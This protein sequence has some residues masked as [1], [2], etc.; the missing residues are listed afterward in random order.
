MMPKRLIIVSAVVAL[1]A[2]AYAAGRHT[3][4]AAQATSDSAT[5]P[6]ADDHSSHDLDRGVAVA[7]ATSQATGIPAG[8]GTVA[9]RLAQSPRHGTWEK[10]P[11]GA[12]TIMAW[13]VYP[14]RSER[15]PVVI[16]I[17]ENTGLTTWARGVADQLAA[18]GF[19]GIAP[20]L[21]SLDRGVATSDTLTGEQGR[22]LIGR[23][24]PDRMNAMV[25]AVAKY[26]MG[27][28]AALPMYGI[29]GFCWGGAASFNHAVH[30][31]TGL[32]ASVVYY[33]S[34][35][36]AER[37]SA[38][39]VPVLGLY[40][41]NDARINAGI[42]ATDSAMKALGKSFTHHTYAGAGHGFLRG[43]DGNAANADA[44]RQAWPQT[45]AFFRQHLRG[46]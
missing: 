21:L 23:V 41:G 3:A 16:A 38:I 12:D 29:V 13:V 26:G 10:I 6:H 39:R 34:A 27:L 8:A 25:D 24:T 14:E 42:P 18:D 22:A 45:I 36:P 31:P 11:M 17:H 28:P 1:T 35:P 43:Q 9:A 30:N 2:V 40:G 46:N 32:R 44:S 19:I 5:T 15:A 4:S 33:G 37:L 7:D 20:D